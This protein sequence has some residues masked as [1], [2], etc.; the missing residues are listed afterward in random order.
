MWRSILGSLAS[1]LNLLVG[2]FIELRH[3]Y[4]QLV[5]M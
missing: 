1:D 4:T 5:V 3:D 2:W